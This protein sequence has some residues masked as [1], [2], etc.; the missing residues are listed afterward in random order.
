MSQQEILNTIKY[1][2]HSFFPDARILLFGSKARGDFKRDSDYG[3]LIITKKTLPSRE[4]IT[5]CS[6]IDKALVKAVHAPFDV[7]LDSEEEVTSKKELPGHIIRK[8]I[9][10]GFV[11]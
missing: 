5:W 3:I 4:K 11:L 7:L 2:V 6:K 10:E 8:A 1:T 9:H